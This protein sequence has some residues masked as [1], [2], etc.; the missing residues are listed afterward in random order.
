MKKWLT[1]LFVGLLVLL[2]GCS[3]FNLSYD[4]L[5]YARDATSYLDKVTQFAADTPSLVKRATDNQQAADELKRELQQMK[6]EIIKFNNLDAPETV[7]EFHQQ[8]IEQ[9]NRLVSQ[10]D[11]YLAQLKN[12]LLDPSFLENNQ[13]LQ[14]V[15]E[16]TN[17]VQQIKKL[18]NQVNETLSV[19]QG[20]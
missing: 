3:F 16:I 9:N 1:G 13:L 4:T 11:L 17:I 5:D 10:I 19:S 12:G 14:P 18:N 20:A 7:R 8:L 15:Q 2:S 6:Q